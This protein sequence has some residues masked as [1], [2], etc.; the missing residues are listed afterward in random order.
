MFSKL[1]EIQDL[2]EIQIFPIFKRNLKSSIFKKLKIFFKNKI[3]SSR[4]S[5]IIKIFK[6]H[7]TSRKTRKFNSTLIFKK[8]TLKYNK[9]CNV[10]SKKMKQQIAKPY[11]KRI[12]QENKF[13]KTSSH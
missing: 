6:K 8:R 12:L 7:N 4:I 1:Q 9:S 2:Q 11:Q 10:T 5:N 3:K 13:T